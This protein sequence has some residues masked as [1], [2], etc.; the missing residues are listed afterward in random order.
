[1]VN[2]GYYIMVNNGEWLVGGWQN[3]SEQYDFVSWGDDI[4]NI[5]KITK[6]L[7]PPTKYYIILCYI[8]L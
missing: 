3:P 4:P 7:K 1:M 5:W 8:I 2:D 6:W